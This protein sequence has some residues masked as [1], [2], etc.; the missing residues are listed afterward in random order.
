MLNNKRALFF[1]L[2]LLFTAKVM[3]LISKNIYSK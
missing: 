3:L 2:Q 1:L